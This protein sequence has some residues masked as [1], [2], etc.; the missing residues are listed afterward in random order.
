MWKGGGREGG[1]LQVPKGE[2]GGHDLGELVGTVRVRG[3]SR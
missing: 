2:Y 1:G 3:H